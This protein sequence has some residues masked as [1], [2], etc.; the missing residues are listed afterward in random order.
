MMLPDRPSP[1]PSTKTYTLA[2]SATLTDFVP[3]GT[4]IPRVTGHTFSDADTPDGAAFHR[5]Q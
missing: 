4:T 5:V 2:R 1:P 3:I